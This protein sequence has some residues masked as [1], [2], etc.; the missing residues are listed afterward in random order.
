MMHSTD[1]VDKRCT[2]HNV[3]KVG[4][5]EEEDGVVLKNAEDRG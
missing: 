1:R 4:E 5:E 2:C 3:A